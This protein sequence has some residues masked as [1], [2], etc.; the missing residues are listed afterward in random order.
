LITRIGDG[1]ALT[2]GF[3]GPRFREYMMVAGWYS[4]GR[5]DAG[6]IHGDDE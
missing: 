1:H 2:I 6:M 4:F 3:F 5:L